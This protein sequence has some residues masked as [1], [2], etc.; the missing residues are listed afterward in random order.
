V[1]EIRRRTQE[2]SMAVQQIGAAMYE[3][4]GPTPPP[5]G[6]EKRP[7]EGGETVEGEFREV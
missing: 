3:Q 4:A 7:P 2:L 5:S 6:E 1:S